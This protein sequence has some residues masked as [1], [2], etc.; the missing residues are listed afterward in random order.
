MIVHD[1]Q[2]ARVHGARAHR[3]PGRRR[4]APLA[5]LA[6]IL[7]TWLACA[8]AAQA[9]RFGVEVVDPGGQAVAGASVCVGLPGNYSQ[10]GALFTDAQGRA[11]VDVPN[12]PL[13]LTV[14]KTRFAAVRRSEPARG[15]DLVR[16]VVLSDV[17]RP[18]PRCRADSS[19]AGPS[20][21]LRID[22]VTVL[23]D[24]QRGDGSTRLAISASGSPT[25]Y[26]LSDSEDFFASPWQRFDSQVAVPDALNLANELYLQLRRYAGDDEGSLEAYSPTM[27]V[28]LWAEMS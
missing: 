13:V 15:F 8:S 3:A 27:T 21:G 18:G 28:S 24:A 7:V 23:R 12:V 22:D 9:A 5:T 14:S 25:H 19:L 11:S 20:I 16:Q 17:A 6:G 10:F 4:T 1:L 26:R 2:G